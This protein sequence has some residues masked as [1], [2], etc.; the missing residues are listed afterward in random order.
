MYA[1]AEQ[2]KILQLQI[3]NVTARMEEL[4]SADHKFRIERH[5]FRHKLQAIAGL[6]EKGEYDELLALAREYDETIREIPVT[7]YCEHPV[8]DAVLATYLQK[9]ENAHIRVT[10]RM[11]FPETLPVKEAELA[12]V[13]ANAIENAIHACCLLP[14]TDRWLRI[15]ILTSPRF[16]IQISNPFSGTVCFDDEGIPVSRKQGHGFGTRSIVA[17]CKKNEAFYEFMTA[18]DQFCLRIVFG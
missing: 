5:N 10:T 12:T 18:E 16:M 15:Q 13:F 11:A 8:I 9:A 2:D 3:S 14:E 4:S 7:R 1:L 17:F 6:A